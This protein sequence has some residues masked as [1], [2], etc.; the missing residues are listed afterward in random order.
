[1]R[2][3]FKKLSNIDIESV[4]KNVLYYKFKWSIEQVDIHSF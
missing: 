4:I 3:R 2:N 1:M